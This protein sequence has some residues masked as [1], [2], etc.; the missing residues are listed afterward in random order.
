MSQMLYNPFQDLIFDEHFC[1]LSGVL[2]NEKM[3]VFP[4][5]LMA[6]FKFGDER[7]E[8]MDK[9]K[10]YHY[11]DLVLPCSPEVKLAFDDLDLKIQ[12]AYEKGYEGMAT[13]DQELLF[14]WTGRM[15]YGLLYYEM[16][17]ERDVLLKKG[18]EFQLSPL[19]RKRFS[20]FHLMLQSIIEPITFIGK[21]PWSIVVFPLKYSADIFSYR[22]DTI[23]LMFSFGVDGFGFIACL[24]DNGVIKENQKEVLE[25]MKDHV[26]HPVQ[27]EE[28]YARFHYTDYI[29]QYAPQ[30][31]IENGDDGITIEIDETAKPPKFGFWDED[32]YAQLLSNYWQVYG[33]EKDHILPPQRPRLS[34]LENPY[35]QDFVDPE[36]IS[37]PY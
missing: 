4:E 16:C 12:S 7:V 32:V 18:E 13:L 3:T 25:K 2:T 23:N 8:M 21:K 5:W 27:F 1:F 19:L 9:A 31:K 10:S 17:Y 29:L 15:V 36:S 22:D 11:E 6:H 28:L 33:I 35:T 37:L 14:Q 30:Y 34:F 26:L 24:Q 20:E